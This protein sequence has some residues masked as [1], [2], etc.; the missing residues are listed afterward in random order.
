M[1]TYARQMGI[2]K[3]STRSLVSSNRGER[4]FI[5]TP[6]LQWYLQHGLEVSKVYKVVQL[7][8]R[9][10]FSDFAKEVSSARLAGAQDPDKEILANTFKLWGNSAYGRNVMRKDKHNSIK[11]SDES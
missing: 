8:P 4:Q 5:A 3:K 1:K 7:T 11:Y 2:S 10:A 6:L 9:K